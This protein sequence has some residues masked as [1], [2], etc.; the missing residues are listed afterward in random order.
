VREV[1]EESDISLVSCHNILTEKLGMHRVAA[2]FVP[3]LLTDEQ[4]EQRVGINQELLDQANSD[5]NLLKN[6]V[7]GDETWV[8]GYDVETKA[9]SSQWVSKHLP[10][11]KSAPSSI[12]RQGHVDCFF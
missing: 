11:R 10:D 8:Y 2:K 4:R 6:I 12:E 5:G 1:A 3:R 9:H 7:T